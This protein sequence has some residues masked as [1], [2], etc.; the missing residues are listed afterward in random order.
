M[1]ATLNAHCPAIECEG[2]AYSIRRSLGRLPGVQNVHVDIAGKDVTVTYDESQVAAKALRQRLD[3]A[4][5]PP[6]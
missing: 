4:G 2:C 1:T 3:Q 6:K 5:F